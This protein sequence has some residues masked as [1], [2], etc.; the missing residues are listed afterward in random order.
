MQ[1]MSTDATSAPKLTR[2]IS[3]HLAELREL[4]KSLILTNGIFYN[5]FS[6]QVGFET[7]GTI[8]D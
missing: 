6:F 5:N 7:P 8:F 4:Y 2:L 1:N 3:T